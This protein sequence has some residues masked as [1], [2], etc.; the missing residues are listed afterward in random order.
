VENNPPPQRPQF[1]VFHVLWLT[2]IAI[3]SFFAGQK[4]SFYWGKVGWAVGVLLGIA[5]GF[6]LI[7]G[8]W[9]LADFYYRFRPL[10]PICR[11]GKCHSDDYEI[12]VVAR[13]G[14][15]ESENRCKCG[16]TYVKREN[17]FML[18]RPDGSTHSYMLRKPFHNWEPDKP[19]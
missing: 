11:H 13:E 5:C 2:F 7:Y 12:K 9:L 3:C 17:Q 10:R 1:T 6:L 16:D 18:L 4:L 8:L 19:A 15:W 14:C